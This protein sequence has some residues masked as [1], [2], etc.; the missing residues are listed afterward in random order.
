MPVTSTMAGHVNLDA[1]L[2]DFR[3]I[4][5]TWRETAYPGETDMHIVHKD[6]VARFVAAKVEL[7]GTPGIN[8]HNRGATRA[9]ATIRVH[10]FEAV[11]PYWHSTPGLAKNGDPA[12]AVEFRPQCG[13]YAWIHPEVEAQWRADE[14]AELALE[15]A[16]D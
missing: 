14:A 16:L 4:E 13:A 6:H 10:A 9:I 8:P 15:A 1:P 3:G 11:G 7:H 2:R 12:G 5:I